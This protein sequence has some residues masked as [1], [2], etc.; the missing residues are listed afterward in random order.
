MTLKYISAHQ[1]YL[2]YD[3]DLGPVCVSLLKKDKK[4]LVYI[5]TIYKFKAI[6]IDNAL[7]VPTK[8]QPE[9]V[10]SPKAGNI[11]IYLAFE[12]YLSELEDE[13]FQLEKWYKSTKFQCPSMGEPASINPAECE[14]LSKDISDKIR[15]HVATIE[16]VRSNLNKIVSGLESIDDLSILSP[17][18]YTEVMM[19]KKYYYNDII[20]L[21]EPDQRTPSQRDTFK[22]F[23]RMLGSPLI[24]DGVKVVSKSHNQVKLDNPVT[25]QDEEVNLYND[26]VINYLLM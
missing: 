9:N 17:L 2:G 6:T 26:D 18:K 16:V 23:K 13:W 24:K 21:L 12:K 11:I 8:G 19:M 14:T 3:E 25:L 5:R 4:Y 1:T 22:M 7:L 10:L 15:L 20:L